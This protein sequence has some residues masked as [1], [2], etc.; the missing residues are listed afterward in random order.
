[1]RVRDWSKEEFSDKGLLFA[2][3]IESQVSDVHS[4]PASREVVINYSRNEMNCLKMISIIS[5]TWQDIFIEGRKE[6]GSG[7]CCEVY[8]QDSGDTVMNPPNEYSVIFEWW[9]LHVS[10]FCMIW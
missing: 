5:L 8:E 10:L 9:P 4:C 1:M 7:F 3:A 2:N 6:S